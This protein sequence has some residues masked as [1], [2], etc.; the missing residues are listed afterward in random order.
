[1]ARVN[2]KER[3]F[4]IGFDK[5]ISVGGSKSGIYLMIVGDHFYVGRSIYISSRAYQH[6]AEIHK[7]FKT[8]GNDHRRAN[9][10]HY[11]LK[12]YKYLILHQE[13]NTVCFKMIQ[14]CDTNDDFKMKL[15]E[16]LWLDKYIVNSKC[17]NVGSNAV[18]RSERESFEYACEYLTSIK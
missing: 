17:L 10:S 5:S 18:T 11:L 12:V 6:L 15:A 3:R 2:N 9:Q 16:Q 14:E 7:L 4:D 8:H 1:M 13:V